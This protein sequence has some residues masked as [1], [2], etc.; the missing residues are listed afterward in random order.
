MTKL[1]TTF[2]NFVNAPKN[3]YTFKQWSQ[4]SS[5]N[6]NTGYRLDDQAIM[7]QLPATARDYIIP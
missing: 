1:I 3:V 4:D 7:A 6:V 5:F 2:H